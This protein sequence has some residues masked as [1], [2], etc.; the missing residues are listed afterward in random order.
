VA[1]ESLANAPARVAAL[2]AGSSYW[3]PGGAPTP[4]ECVACW[5]R[6]R[7]PVR[8]TRAGATGSRPSWERTTIGIL[9]YRNIVKAHIV[10]N[11]GAGGKAMRYW[12]RK[13]SNSPETHDKE[14]RRDPA[15]THEA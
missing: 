14:T 7:A 5:P 15:R 1:G 8:S 11:N 4:P 12:H 6:A 9:S 2:L 13:K 10:E 3:L